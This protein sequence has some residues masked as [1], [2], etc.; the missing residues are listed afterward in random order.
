MTLPCPGGARCAA[1]VRVRRCLPC[2]QRRC[3]AARR[4]LACRGRKQGFGTFFPSRGLSRRAG[5]Q[6]N[7][8]LPARGGVFSTRRHPYALPMSLS[9]QETEIRAIPQSERTLPLPQNLPHLSIRGKRGP[10]QAASHRP[11]HFAA[12]IRRTPKP[13]FPRLFP[14]FPSPPHPPNHPA[15]RTAGSARTRPR[16]QT[17]ENPILGSGSRFPAASIPQNAAGGRP[18]LVGLPP[19]T[20]TTAPFGTKRSKT[21]PCSWG[22]RASN[23]R[24]RHCQ[25][26]LPARRRT[27]S[28]RG[29]SAVY[30]LCRRSRNETKRPCP[31]LVGHGRVNTAPKALAPDTIG[32]RR[33]L[34]RRRGRRRSFAGTPQSPSRPRGRARG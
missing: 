21:A 14:P 31:L 7:G 28:A 2:G 29:P 34:F 10:L 32:R 30:A 3:R 19:S 12:N 17:L 11:P 5:G 4:I 26:A 33:R 9:P 18:L 23:P 13:S 22:G 16:V 1:S 25:P 20:P 24:Q 27:A 6:G 8:L 15:G